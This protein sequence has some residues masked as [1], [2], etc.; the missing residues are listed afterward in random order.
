VIER[1]KVELELVES[2]YGSVQTGP[3]VEWFIIPRW[4]LPRG[5]SKPETDLLVLIPPG[6]PVTPPDNF[7]VDGDLRVD[8][9]GMPG[10]ASHES[11]VDRQWLR[12]SWHVEGG[13][14]S[15]HADPLRGHN[16][17]TFL[18]AVKKRLSEPN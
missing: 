2:S 3:N 1:W 5:W 6:Y 7:Y 10:S 4:P 11:Q 8:S 17:L 12:F 9:A 13:D 16:L 14:W 15:P 18:L